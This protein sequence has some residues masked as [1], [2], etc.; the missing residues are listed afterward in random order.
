LDN[1]HIKRKCKFAL[2]KLKRKNKRFQ[3]ELKKL[4]RN[5]PNGEVGSPAVERRKF[6][7]IWRLFGGSSRL[8]GDNFGE[9]FG[10]KLYYNLKY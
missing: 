7:I 9:H 10:E 5:L 2:N 6:K 3:I 4:D 8:F 1:R